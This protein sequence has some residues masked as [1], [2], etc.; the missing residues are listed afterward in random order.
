MTISTQAELDAAAIEVAP[1]NVRDYDQLTVAQLQRRDELNEAIKPWVLSCKDE[2]R[3][4]VLDKYLP[5]AVQQV[6]STIDAISQYF[7]DGTKFNDDCLAKA[8]AEEPIFVLRAQDESSP[9]VILHWIAKNLETCPDDKL[10]DAFE[11]VLK[12]K[13]WPGRKPAD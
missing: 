3:G 11:H 10:R 9:K 6:E 8:D 1:L 5:G 13:N 7:P 12:M 4:E 2:K